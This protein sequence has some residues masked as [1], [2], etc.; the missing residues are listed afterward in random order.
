MSKSR[1]FISCALVISLAASVVQPGMAIAQVPSATSVGAVAP[2]PK[3]VPTLLAPEDAIPRFEAAPTGSALPE[4]VKRGPEQVGRR[5][6]NVKE[7]VLAD[8]RNQVEVS[9]RPVHYR[10][11]N[12]QWQEIDTRI[13]KAGAGA[14]YAYVNE[15]NMFASLFGSTTDRLATFRLGGR[16][17]RLGAAGKSTVVEPSAHGD[18]V[19][20][21][22]VF[23]DADVT[24]QV[25]PDA[26]KEKIVLDKPPAD[27]TYTFTLDVAGVQTRQREDG[28]IAFLRPGGEGGPVFVMP[29]PFMI[30][31]RDDANSP[32]G[33][34]WSGKV[35]QT[36][37]PDGD[38]FTV[39]VT[40]DMDWLRAPERKYPVAIDP[41]IK[42]QPT[43]T[44]AQDVMVT[45]DEPDRNHDG[46]W[47]LSVGTTGAGSARSL[48]NF[49]LAGIPAGTQLDSAQLQVYYDQ[50][51]T[52]GA[53]DVAIEARRVTVPWTAGTATWNSVNN[54]FAEMGHNQ[55]LV[56][57]ADT[58]KTA[59]NGQWPV[60]DTGDADQAINH[61]YRV[62]R[63]ASTGESFAWVPRLTEP[64]E[65]QVEAHYVAGADRAI[66]APYTVHHAGGQQTVPVNQ[67]S[68]D[69]KSLGTWTFTAGTAHKIVLG[70]VSNKAVIADAVRLT[71]PGVQ[72]K[73]ANKANVW[74][75][76]SVRSTVQNWLSGTQPN[77]GFLLKA[78]D[79]T[80]GKGGPRYAAA[81]YAYN[82]ETAHTPK[83][84]LTY[85]KPG[86]NLAAPTTIRATGA[87]LKWTPY[88]G[89][90]IVEYQV[91]RSVHQR[92]TPSAAT[93]VAPVKPVVTGYADTTAEPTR[94]DD[95]QPFGNA[96]YYVVAVKTR[97]G[98]LIPSQTQL[99][100][101]PKAGRAV[102][103]VQGDATDTTLTAKQPDAGHD[104]L[105]GE[106][107]LMAGN[108]S[109]TFGA[110]RP[111]V[112]FDSLA[113]IPV[114]ARVV[115]AEASLWASRPFRTVRSAR[116]STNCTG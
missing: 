62:N 99:V 48:L 37:K 103:I 88:A 25:T 30:D 26:L 46:S 101:L 96:F 105:A 10:D 61:S 75:S 108:S 69:W 45:S 17:V 28:S 82:G 5:T 97:D 59:V 65:Y 86:A 43:A 81:E 41:T 42:I 114:G 40:A 77:H 63:N 11:A 27:A 35:T 83:L 54:G 106:P 49:D 112:R 15:R 87:D 94:A 55:E 110:S 38:R 8:G 24:Y 71:K 4:E 98:S 100:R 78:A 67:T 64:G 72:I 90:D 1:A 104:A 79:E 9:S 32:Y 80:L 18:S 44:Q 70:D 6:A 74:H 21:P 91:H 2:Q 19:F 92:F 56:D 93:L 22:N 84:V 109:G 14:G 51:H 13:S 50:D 16:E 73:K 53:N 107:W 68:G 20:Y 23:G 12:G 29:K 89:D 111:V 85:G 47:R 31:A 57:N 33:K 116:V 66:N 34:A 7:F 113:G 95:P 36:I 102:K 115:D 39:T 58:G 76:F 3:V 60:T 52:T